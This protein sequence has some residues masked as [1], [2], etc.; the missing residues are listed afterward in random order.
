MHGSCLPLLLQLQ[1]AQVARECA[2]LTTGRKR[3][4]HVIYMYETFGWPTVVVS[5]HGMVV[6]CLIA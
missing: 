4:L 1:V 2:W 6:T 5:R 3:M